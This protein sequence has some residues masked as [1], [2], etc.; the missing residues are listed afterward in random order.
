MLIV[1]RAPTSTDPMTLAVSRGVSPL[2]F[3]S[4]R[5][6]PASMRTWAHATLP[7]ATALCKGVLPSES[8]ALTDEPLRKSNLVVVV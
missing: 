8:M 4:V 5:S 6:A 1:R 7:E 3:L 2:L